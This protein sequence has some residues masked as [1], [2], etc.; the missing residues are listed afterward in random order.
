[1]AFKRCIGPASAT[2]YSF[3]AAKGTKPAKPEAQQGRPDIFAHSPRVTRRH[4][5]PENPNPTS[6]LHGMSA[7]E[8]D[9][10]ARERSF[11][12]NSAHLTHSD[13]EKAAALVA[14]ERLQPRSNPHI[15][16]LLREYINKPSPVR[17]GKFM[18]ELVR[19]PVY[20]LVSEAEMALRESEIQMAAMRF[21]T[22]DA[23]L[24]DKTS[25]SPLLFTERDSDHKEDGDALMIKRQLGTLAPDYAFKRGSASISIFTDT[26]LLSEATKH[27]YLKSSGIDRVSY[28]GIA[29]RHVIPWITAEQQNGGLSVYLNRWTDLEAPLE[30]QDVTEIDTYIKENQ[31]LL[32]LADFTPV[33][34]END[35]QVSETWNVNEDKRALYTKRR[36]QILQERKAK[37]IGGS[38]TE[39]ERALSL[40]ARIIADTTAHDAR[41]TVSLP[42]IQH[43]WTPQCNETVHKVLV[44]FFLQRPE[45]RKV[46]VLS[47]SDEVKLLLGVDSSDLSATRSKLVALSRFFERTELSFPELVDVLPLQALE[48][49]PAFELYTRPADLMQ[50][51]RLRPSQPASR[52]TLIDPD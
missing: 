49:E 1:M 17:Y 30:A 29:M 5:G 39:T 35:G 10:K 37:A 23:S 11:H 22:A 15:S 7:A 41:Q 38:D 19:G 21:S 18:S 25:F 32:K 6:R 44:A 14:G 8:A 9:Q 4:I 12:I 33:L 52:A 27:P 2:G 50:L 28:I 3:R 31:V 20:V 51:S 16:R 24:P 40:E 26:E 34:A 42:L 43:D 36:R 45:V 47:A 48:N 46:V 13:A